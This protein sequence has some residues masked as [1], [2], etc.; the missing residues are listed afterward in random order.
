[1]QSHFDHKFSVSSIETIFATICFCCTCFELAGAYRS[2]FGIVQDK[3]S[4]HSVVLDHATQISSLRSLSCYSQR[5]ASVQS[6]EQIL[7]GPVFSASFSWFVL[8]LLN[9]PALRDSY[10]ARLGPRN[11]SF[12][13]SRLVHI[14]APSF[15][16]SGTLPSLPS[17]SIARSACCI[18]FYTDL[19]RSFTQH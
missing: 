1:M 11:M 12:S 4:L 3:L 5:A 10:L 14:R 6:F 13:S 16:W 19:F 8:L 7:E 2:S 18:V 15:I 9:I 17:F